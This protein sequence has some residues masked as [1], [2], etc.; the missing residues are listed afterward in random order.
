M[1]SKLDVHFPM[2]LFEGFV[3]LHIHVTEGGSLMS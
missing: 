2:I 3:V 1:I